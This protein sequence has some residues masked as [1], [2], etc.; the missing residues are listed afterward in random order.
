MGMAIKKNEFKVLFSH[1]KSSIIISNPEE[2]E[3]DIWHITKNE[4]LNSQAISEKFQKIRGE[5][6]N[7]ALF[8][9]GYLDGI[10]M[11]TFFK[12]DKSSNMMDMFKDLIL[13]REFFTFMSKWK[14]IRDLLHNNILHHENYKQLLTDTKTIID[15]RNK[16][17]HGNLIICGNKMILS[18]FDGK[19]C[20]EEIDK[21]KIDELNKTFGRSYYFL[22]ELHK[23][24]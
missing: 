12:Q 4:L 3:G 6:I 20:E 11:Q 10:I 24:V 2:I 23:S 9:E 8:I 14:V 18:F 1:P 13:S 19:L 17:A 5:G 7:R 15:E 16:F 22:E 21:K